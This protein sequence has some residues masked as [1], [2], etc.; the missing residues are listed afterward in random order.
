MVPIL[1]RVSIVIV[2]FSMWI[3][4]DRNNFFSVNNYF[5]SFGDNKQELTAECF[6]KLC[7][8]KSPQLRA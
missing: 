3:L 2:V 6:Y 1:S 4:V 8:M 5:K 7:V